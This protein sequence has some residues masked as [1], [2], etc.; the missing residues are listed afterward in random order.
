VDGRFLIIDTAHRRGHVALARGVRVV[1]ARQ[2]EESRRHARDLVPLAQELLR[3]QAWQARD[4]A[5]VIVSR[6]PGSYTGLRVGV[7]SAKTLAYATG[8]ALLGVD[9]FAAIALQAPP[10]ARTVDVLADAQQGKVYAQRFIQGK[11]GAL[12]I[13]PFPVWLETL[14]PA[15]WVTGS[16]LEIFSADLPKQVPQVEC[17]DWLPRPES[18][19]TLALARFGRGDK[20]DP[21]ALEPIYLRG[22]SAEEKVARA[23]PRLKE[24]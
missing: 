16:G 9:T 3:E 10:E 5:G 17:A 4:L 18:L 1:G 22:S 2:L 23:T 14:P 11:G 8:C 7:M 12:T 21:F 24:R 15:A 20:D 19:L 13:Q 6:G